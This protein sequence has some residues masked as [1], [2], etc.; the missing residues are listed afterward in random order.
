MAIFTAKL[1]RHEFCME[2]LRKIGA[3]II[4]MEGIM[5]LVKYNN[6][7]LKI[8]YMYHLNP[9]NTYTLER[10][11]PHSLH[12][13]EFQSEEDLVEIIKVDVE[14]L[15]NAK[16]SKNFDRF[17]SIDKSLAKIVRHF[18]DLF[19]YYNID[20]EDMIMLE[21]ETCNFKKKIMEV[22]ERSKRIYHKKDPDSFEG[23]K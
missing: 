9:D 22:K 23:E 19:L 7:G 20:R 4:N 2:E 14:Q 6:Q 11:K 18:D 3:E 16:N 12:I 13:G 10:I 15:L 21:Q 1:L 17:V 5:F 8:E